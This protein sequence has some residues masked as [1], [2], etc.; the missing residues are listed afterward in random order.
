MAINIYSKEEQANGEF[1]GGGILENKPIGFP[2]DGRGGIKPFSNI[3]YWAHAWT[4]GKESLIGEHPHQGFEIITFVLTGSIKHY[5]SKL[6]EWQ[7]LEAGDVQIIRAGNGI[8]H[9]ELIHE[10]SSIFQIW[11]DPDL[12]ISLQQDASYDNYKKQAFIDSDNHNARINYYVGGNSP[13]EMSTIGIEIYDLALNN[14]S[15][16]LNLNSGKARSFYVLEGNIK[17]N[18]NSL[19]PHDF[20][21][22]RDENLLKLE[23]EA[24][25]RIFVI[26]LLKEPGYQTYAGF[27][28]LT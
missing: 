2:Q 22:F 14:T 15:Y 17:A 12:S 9:A 8:S 24:N 1:N 5:D 21:I 3:F 26:D 20:V 10:D 25:A 4:P 7:L 27:N 23:A 13:L 16:S 11:F 18:G 19:Q 6:K 28:N